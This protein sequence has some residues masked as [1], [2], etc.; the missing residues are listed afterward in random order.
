VVIKKFV[1]GLEPPSGLRLK[2]NYKL[3][4]KILQD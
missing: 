1:V 4:S 3:E 2:P